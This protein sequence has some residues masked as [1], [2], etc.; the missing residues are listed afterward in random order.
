M[1]ACPLLEQIFKR[2][3]NER[4]G[5][6]LVPA[7]LQPQVETQQSLVFSITRCVFQHL[8]CSPHLALPGPS[9][10]AFF[11]HSNPVH[12]SV[13]LPSQSWALSL[14]SAYFWTFHRERED[15]NA[16]SFPGMCARKVHR[17]RA[18]GLEFTFSLSLCYHGLWHK[19]ILGLTQLPAQLRSQHGLG[20]I[21]RRMHQA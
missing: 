13:I 20:I 2:D 5:K 1:T 8:L 9:S 3:K 6:L 19:F 21:P 11:L 14:T 4:V 15:E 12:I 17:A 10:V 18:Q 16:L 7:C